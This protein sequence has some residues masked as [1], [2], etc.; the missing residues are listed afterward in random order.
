MRVVRVENAQGEGPYRGCN[1]PAWDS[2]AFTYDTHP[3]PTSDFG[4]RDWWCDLD[5]AIS[6]HYVFAFRDKEQL[7][8]WFYRDDWVYQLRVAG[9]V[10][11]T[12]EVSYPDVRV[13]ERQAVFIKER[14]QLVASEEIPMPSHQFA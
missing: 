10:L 2:S 11:A 14:A 6:R 4:L 13:G 8:E 7:S 5:Y 3:T 12:Y 9:F 1:L